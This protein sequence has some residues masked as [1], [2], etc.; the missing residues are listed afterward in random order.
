MTPEQR[1]EIIRRFVRAR[2]SG[3]VKIGLDPDHPEYETVNHLA[4][5]A[6]LKTYPLSP[7]HDR[8]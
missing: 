5:T 8:K 7:R 2:F 3:I 1:V 4:L 6:G